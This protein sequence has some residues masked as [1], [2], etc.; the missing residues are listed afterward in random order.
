VPSAAVACFVFAGFGSALVGAGSAGELAVRDGV[1][2][3]ELASLPALSAAVVS[4]SPVLQPVSR[5]APAKTAARPR[6]RPRPGMASWVLP[7]MVLFPVLMHPDRRAGAAY[8]PAP[9]GRSGSAPRSQVQTGPPRQQRSA[10]RKSVSQTAA[11]SVDDSI[12]SPIAASTAGLTAYRLPTAE[13]SAAPLA[14]VTHCGS[15]MT[16]PRKHSYAG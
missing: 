6:T 10:N 9:A 2:V 11:R 16:R 15:T 5:T 3:A 4:V 1:G 13:S 7:L 14:N 12:E 8:R